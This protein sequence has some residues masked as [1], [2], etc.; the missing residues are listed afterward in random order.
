MKFK[1]NEGVKVRDPISKQHVPADGIEV[2]ESAPEVI[3]FYMRRVRDGHMTVV[4]DAK[5][6]GAAPAKV[7]E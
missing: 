4:S 7:K 3:T 6:T 2:H 5:P 1:P